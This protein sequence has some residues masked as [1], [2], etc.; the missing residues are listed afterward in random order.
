MELEVIARESKTEAQRTPLLFVHG[1]G[2]GAWCWAE[3]FLDYFAARGYSSYAL[4]LRGHGQSDGKD[5]LQWASVKD[6]VSDVAQVADGLR[7][8][9]ILIGHSL[10][11]LVVQKYLEKHDAPAAVLVASSP[12]S[13][14]FLRGLS[15]FCQH[16][17]LFTK[18]FFTLDAGTV[19]GTP[20]L[21]RKMLFSAR[22]ERAKVERYASQCGRESF[23]AFLEMMFYLPKPRKVRTPMLVLGAANDAIVRPRDIEKTGRAYQAPVKIFPDMAHDM[24]LEDGWEDVAAYILQW[25]QKKGL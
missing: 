3:N 15:L 14:M 24:M 9:P 21:V 1:S 23:R 4:S 10:G 20:A 8:P 7:R 5:V 16:P 2:H 11:G 12:V 17:L 25:L 6:Y 13:G 19:Y 18:T 22:T